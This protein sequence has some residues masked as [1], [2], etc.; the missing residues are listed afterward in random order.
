MC[1]VQSA[2][3]AVLI[4]TNYNNSFWKHGHLVLLFCGVQ[5]SGESTS[6]LLAGQRWVITVYCATLIQSC[7]PAEQQ[8]DHKKK[9][10]SPDSFLSTSDSLGGDEGDA[11]PPG[12]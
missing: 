9:N 5:Q 12:E 1:Y 7:Q 2:T 11:I 8:Q 3:Q 4:L 6:C 10:M